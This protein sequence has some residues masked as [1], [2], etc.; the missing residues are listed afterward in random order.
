MAVVTRGGRAA[1]TRYRVLRIFKDVAAMV[2]CRLATGRTHQIRVHL[3][4]HGNPLIGD[5][6]YGRSRGRRRALEAPVRAALEAF[7][8]QAL[9][10]ARL[11]FKHPASG[12]WLQFESELPSDMNWLIAILERLLG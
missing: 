7:P 11:G 5:P 1:L 3:A 2:E 10:A 4:A 12:E 9:H 6:V 8:R